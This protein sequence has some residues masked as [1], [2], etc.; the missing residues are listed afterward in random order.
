MKKLYLVVRVLGVIVVL[1]GLD[2]CSVPRDNPSDTRPLY[3]RG[4]THK[5]DPECKPTPTAAPVSYLAP[6]PAPAEVATV[7][8]GFAPR[9]AVAA[10]PNIRMSTAKLVPVRLARPAPL[11]IKELLLL[12]MAG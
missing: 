11:A 12:P 1:L 4:I 5:N 3:C 6:L 9:P 10:T 2:E 8:P 7:I